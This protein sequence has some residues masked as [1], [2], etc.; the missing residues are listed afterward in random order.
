MKINLKNNKN[1]SIVNGSVIVYLFEGEE[2]SSM[3]VSENPDSM[4]PRL[5]NLETFCL[6]RFDFTKKTDI[7]N[8]PDIT[9]LEV[10]HPNN[11]SLNRMS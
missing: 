6:D 11:L 9:I 1:Y 2:R 10:I 4:K 7:L 3:V 8:H 5:V